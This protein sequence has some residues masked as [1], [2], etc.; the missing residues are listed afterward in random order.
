MNAATGSQSAA[1]ESS[2]DKFNTPLQY[3]QRL[4]SFASRVNKMLNKI[5]VE[6]QRLVFLMHDVD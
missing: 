2:L 6:Y 3:Y 1:A 4:C 5:G